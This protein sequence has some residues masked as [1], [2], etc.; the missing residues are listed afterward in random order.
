MAVGQQVKAKALARRGELAEAE[1]LARDAVAI[2]DETER[3]DSQGDAYASLAEV[4]LLAGR[5]DESAAALRQA[6]DRFERKE[7]LAMAGRV[8]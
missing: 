1:R 6:L 2:C 4:V 8:L 3:L 7:N 5:A